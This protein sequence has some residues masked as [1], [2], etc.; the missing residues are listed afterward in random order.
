MLPLAQGIHQKNIVGEKANQ[1]LSFKD[2]NWLISQYMLYP[3]GD[4]ESK[5]K[6]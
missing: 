4:G 3:K 5:K 2:R 6:S 1:N